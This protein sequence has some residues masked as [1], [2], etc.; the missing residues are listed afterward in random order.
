MKV[1]I[2]TVLS[3]LILVAIVNYK[4]KFYWKY[5]A[6]IKW[7]EIQPDIK[8]LRMLH[9]DYFQ[10]LKGMGVLD[11]L[12]FKTTKAKF[13]K[14]KANYY[15]YVEF[16]KSKKIPLSS[17][18][19]KIASM[20]EETE[21]A[22]M[23]PKELINNLL[24]RAQKNY[25]KEYES[26]MLSGEGLLAERQNSIA[27]ISEIEELINTIAQR[28]KSFD[29]ALEEIKV[30]KVKFQS[31]IDF[32]NLE[33]ENLKNGAKGMGIGVAVGGAVAGLAPTT[34]LWIAYSS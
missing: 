24:K 31:A 18:Q 13:N 17:E 26:M 7:K 28:P 21:W 22:I 9:K 19:E 33:R 8:E 32:A 6:N 11:N 10:D 3:I 16:C 1:F 29:V 12:L 20:I 2:L 15:D 5:Q 34:A 14:V 23:N 4:T 27:L 30:E 25:D